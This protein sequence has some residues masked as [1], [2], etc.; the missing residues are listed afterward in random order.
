MN[1][2]SSI[3]GNRGFMY[4]KETV[5]NR[6]HDCFTS[7]IICV[8]GTSNEP[9]SGYLSPE[10]MCCTPRFQYKN[11]NSNLAIQIQLL[12]HVPTARLYS[13]RGWPVTQLCLGIHSIL[14]WLESDDCFIGILRF[15]NHSMT[16][17][18]A[19][20]T[21]K[22]GRSLQRALWYEPVHIHTMQSSSQF[23]AS[24]H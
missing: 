14:V 22:R 12:R 23:H 17:G 4:D 7:L 13:E 18:I 1:Y 2:T 10:H 5:H 8:C 24:L 20:G 9:G 21:G 11:L 3:E 15:F 6:L 19:R 16:S